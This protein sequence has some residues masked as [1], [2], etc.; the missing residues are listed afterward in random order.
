[1]VEKIIDFSVKNRFLVLI[2][3]LLGVILSLNTIKDTP[4]DALPDLSP[5]QVIVQ[6]KWSGQSPL[7]LE[8]QVTYPLI[9]QLLSLPNIETVRAMSSFENG[10]IYVIFKDG[11]DLYLA[12]D[13]ILE[14]LSELNPTFPDGVEVKMGPDATGVGWAYEYALKSNSKS[15]DELRTLQEYY[16]KYALLGIDGVSEVATVGGFVKGYEIKL[17]QDKMVKFNISL[18]DIRKRLLRFNSS[19]GGRL[20][21]ENGYE[22]IIRVNGYL[23]GIEDIEDIT[24]LSNGTDIVKLKDIAEVTLSPQNRRGVADLNGEGEVVGGIIVVRFGENPYRVI[25]R[26]KEKLKTLRVDGVE[27]IGVYDRT[28]LIDKAIYTLRDTL[29]EESIIVLVVIAIFLSHFRSSLIIILTLPLTIL[30]TFLLM[31]LFNIGSNIMSLG[32]ISIA[33]GAMVDATIVMV[34][35]AHKYLHR[36]REDATAKERVVAIVESAK[37]VGRPIFFALV[38]VIV[39]FLPIFSLTGQEGK[40]FTPLAYTKT[41]AMVVGA[42]LSITIVPILM[43]F[44]IRGK[45]VGEEKNLLNRLFQYIYIPLLKVSIKL[46]YLVL[47]LAIAFLVFGYR[48]YDR[49]NWEFMPMMNE[50]TFMYMPVTPYGIGVDMAKELLQKTDMV[51]KSFNEVKSVFGKVGRADSATDPAPL[52]MIETIITL[53]PQE[54]WRDHK[55]YEELMR[56]M[57]R[58]LQIGGL[59]NSW[60]YPIRGRIDM[61]LTGI[62]TPLGI[63]LY[64]DNIDKLSEI[65]DKIEKR[66]RDFNKTLAVSY[67]KS[68]SG[69]YLDID[70]DTKSLSRYGVTK[71]DIL[72]TISYGVGGVKVSTLFHSLE[73]YPIT[74]RFSEESREDITALRELMIET[75][76]GFF[77]LKKFAKLRYIEAPSVIKSEKGM[78]VSFIY[79]TPK[80]GVSSKEYRDEADRLLRDIKLP[81]GYYYEWSG[82]S[83]Y[84]ES[85]ME[86][87]KFIIPLSLVVVFL[88]IYLAFRNLLYSL[89]IFFTL[90]IALS[91]GVFLVDILDVNMSVAVIVGF[92]ALLGV[93]SETSIVMLVYL[94]EAFKNRKRREKLIDIVV[95]GAG[96]RL[97]PKLMTVFA[98]LGGLVPILYIDGVGSEIMRAIAIPMVGGM[99]SSTFLTLFIIP[100]LFFIFKKNIN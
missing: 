70:I 12:R 33:I 60:T 6:V 30:F 96:L 89:I 71:S 15:L 55:S 44:F 21:L 8:E 5:P 77:P 87:L 4:L 74:L 75:D 24:I 23:K 28:S 9:S 53:K 82:Q 35:N 34:E 36:L 99:V 39:S 68:S 54:E 63:K 65:S 52:A 76:F 57:D 38:L 72:N 48:V 3:T 66:L 94:D 25:E 86:R 47:I 10:L 40:L 84:L 79:I 92:I 56:D 11:T 37:V 61:L 83:Q 67:D 2:V 50:Q 26:V 64:G 51:L 17:Y 49:L 43:I 90:P 32:G 95:S 27:V 31:R 88:L 18:D 13:R 22:N 100:I 98:I 1:M 7:I 45:I 85:A 91:G 62:R 81:T 41:F 73:R 59:I 20:I 97:R 16:Y 19:S 29:I 93:A 14:K 46:R 42:I 58:H 78:R 80:S 69:Y